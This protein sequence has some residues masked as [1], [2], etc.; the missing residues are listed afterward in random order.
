VY[1]H[2]KFKKKD[3]LLLKEKYKGNKGGGGINHFN[4]KI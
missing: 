4:P 3:W 2:N 1:S